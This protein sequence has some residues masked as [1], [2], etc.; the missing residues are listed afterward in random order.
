MS[1]TNK[2]R[3]NTWLRSVEGLFAVRCD[4]DDKAVYKLTNST[5]RFHILESALT[6]RNPKHLEALAKDGMVLADYRLAD[7]EEEAPASDVVPQGDFERALSL[8]ARLISDAYKDANANNQQAFNNLVRIAD[9]ATAALRSYERAM[10]ASLQDRA[11]ELDER[12]EDLQ[13]ANPLGALGGLPSLS[14]LGKK[15][16]P[17][18]AE[19]DK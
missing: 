17:K 4:G 13:T 16:E 9:T 2:M 10:M 6:S 18:K 15:E 1:G 3:L 12:E 8:T 7:E 19:G 14:L 11:A 5:R